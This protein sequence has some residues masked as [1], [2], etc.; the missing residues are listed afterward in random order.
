MIGAKEK[1][2]PRTVSEAAIKLAKA[3]E[4]LDY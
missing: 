1:R 4:T 2:M 3:F